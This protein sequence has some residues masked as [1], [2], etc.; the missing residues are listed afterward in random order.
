MLEAGRI[1]KLAINRVSEFG[2]FLIDEEENE[3]LLPNRYVSLDHK[4]GDEIEVFIYH[5]SEDRLVATTETPTL[6]QDEVAYLKVVDNNL[7]G[8][9]LDW[10]LYGKDLFLPNRNQQGGIMVGESYVVYLYEDH[11]TGRC[12]ASN[13][14][15]GYINNDFITVEYK[16]EVDIMLASESPIGFRVIIN[17]RHWGM[18]YRDQI[19]TPVAIGDKMRAFVRRITEDDRIDVS[20]QQQGYAQVKGSAEILFEMIEKNGGF[21]PLND[22]STPDQIS[23]ITKTSK[24]NFKRSLGVLMKRGVVEVTDLGVKSVNTNE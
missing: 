15:K 5:D 21:L 24:K 17:D 23:A 1:Q 14:L 13:K 12:V 7:H 2:L 16:E 18:L 22:N 8:A 11:I 4:V 6:K 20:I 10:G 9:F 3:V 19:F